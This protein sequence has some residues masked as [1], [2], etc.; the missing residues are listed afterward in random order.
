MNKVVAD[1]AEV[2]K[3]TTKN[4]NKLIVESTTFMENFQTTFNNNTSSANKAT[5]DLG[6]LFKSK[7]TQLQAILTGLKTYLETFQATISCQISQLKDELVKEST[8]KDSLKL[9]SEEVKVLSAKLEILK[10]QV[11]DLLSEK[12]VMRSC[13]ADVTY[14][15]EFRNLVYFRNNGEGASTKVDPKPA[16]KKF[17][18]PVTPVPPVVKKEPK[19]K[20]IVQ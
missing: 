10:N 9:N 13:I 5:K 1:S 12:A 19:L 8:I 11:K 16:V 17:V 14:C 3:T 6:S 4:V 15:R 20:E 7:R 18:K 2:C